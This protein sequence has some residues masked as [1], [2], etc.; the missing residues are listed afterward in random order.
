MSEDVFFLIF[1]FIFGLLMG[2][3]YNVVGMRVPLKESIAFPN[4]HCPKCKNQLKW[5]DL[6]PVFSYI[7]LKGK[8]RK[9]KTVISPIYPTME[10]A[11]GLLF[12]AVYSAFGMSLETGFYLVLISMLVVLTVSD[13]K[14]MLIP[15]KIL[16]A[17]GIVLVPYSIFLMDISLKFQLL[18][19]GVAFAI[20]LLIILMT[21]GN[22]MGGGDMK[23]FMLLGFL[24]GVKVF[25]S[26]FFCSVLI[27]LVMGLLMKIKT[28]SNAFPFG[29]SI[30]A[31]TLLNIF[32]SKEVIMIY[33][34]IFF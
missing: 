4:S 15:N 11:T 16:M 33:T 21:R 12:M 7:F 30:A 31:A 19:L 18:G 2:S 17:F 13:L 27:G 14:T 24:V 10:L 20:N 9:C 23:L 34:N 1:F 25:V 22:G 8:C 26:I 29:P 6:V 5:F 32:W 3:F 28:K